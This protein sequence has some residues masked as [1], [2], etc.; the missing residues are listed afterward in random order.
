M[1]IISLIPARGGSKGL[2]EKNIID[3]NGKPLISYT[4]NAS[5]KSKYITKTL[6]SSDDEKILNISLEYGAEIVK[7]PNKLALDTTPTEPVIEHALNYIKNTKDY[8]YLVLLQPTSPLRKEEHIDRAIEMLRKQKATALISTVK[9]DNKILKAF[10]NNK[11]GYLESISNNSYP[12]MRRQDLPDVFMPNGAIYV[13]NIEEFFKTRKL[14]TNKTI[15]F[16]M[17]KEES[18]DID[19]LKDLLVIDKVLKNELHTL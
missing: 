3:L 16:E 1:E 19:T 8:D 10:K 5:L 13:V 9:I 12:F 4:I 17:S 7:R 2:K 11:D 15:S 18:Y 6:V 14:F